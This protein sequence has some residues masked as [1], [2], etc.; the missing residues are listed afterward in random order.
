VKENPKKVW[1]TWETQRR[2]VELSR[3]FGA[4]LGQF[5]FSSLPRIKR[6]MKSAIDTFKFVKSE[7][8]ELV[9]VQCPS[10]VLLSYTSILR[11]FFRFKLVVDAHNAATDL[12]L[13]QPGALAS[14]VAFQFRNAA[15]V[16][17]SN[18]ALAD[19]LRNVGVNSVVLPDALPELSES[20][21]NAIIISKVRESKLKK[22]G[23]ITLICS[24]AS[25][26]PIAEFLAIAP[27]SNMNFKIFCTGRISKAGKLI[28]LSGDRIEFTDFLSH[29]DYDN[30]LRESDLLVDL[31]TR[32]DCLVCGAYEAL[33][34]EKP[35][36]LSDT[37]ALRATFSDTALF[38]A[39]DRESYKNAI[40][41]FFSNKE[42][43]QS[44]MREGIAKFKKR[45]DDQFNQVNNQLNDISG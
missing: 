6:Y 4:S 7:K 45:W 37:K 40:D 25:D 15:A 33:A 16:I 24:F 14:I 11:F 18:S 5:D 2:N 19:K 28:E 32:E 12:V 34:A 39:N 23:V 9:F 43:I 1:L 42:L 17:V 13:A 44:R 30:L 10:V 8:P 29:S 35:I 41:E 3:A 31:T 26:E 38:A 21:N 22:I 36:L 27:L 20:D